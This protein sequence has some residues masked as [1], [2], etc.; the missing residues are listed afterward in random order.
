MKYGFFYDTNKKIG[1]YSQELSCK[2]REHAARLPDGSQ[3]STSCYAIARDCVSLHSID[4]K[5]V[6]LQMIYFSGDL[7]PIAIDTHQLKLQF[8]FRICKMDVKLIRINIIPD[9]LPFL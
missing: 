9:G 7:F 2:F 8:I 5:S 4:D 1:V 3:A 6:I